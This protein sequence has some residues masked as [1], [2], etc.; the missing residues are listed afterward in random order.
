M[1]SASCRQGRTPRPPRPWWRQLLGQEGHWFVV[2]GAVVEAVLLALLTL[3]LALS[4]FVT[5]QQRVSLALS[6]ALQAATTALIPVGS[7]PSPSP[8]AA[9]S[10]FARVFRRNLR[11]LSLPQGFAVT[12]LEV[13]VYDPGQ[14]DP[15]T[16]YRFRA[17]GVGAEVQGRVPVLV[18]SLTLPWRM[19]RDAE[20]V[21]RVGA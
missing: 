15:A 3:S 10:L 13:S 18:S 5:T 16:H 1:P 17:P 14:T 6:S 19:A 2:F 4:Q 8:A 9:Q 21:T 20:L 7:P 12:S 11:S